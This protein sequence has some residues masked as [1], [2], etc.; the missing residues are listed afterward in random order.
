[1]HNKK[2]QLVDKLFSIVNGKTSQGVINHLKEEV[3]PK[4]AKFTQKALEKLDYT[5]TN[6]DNWTTDKDVNNEIKRLLH[7]YM[8][9]YNDLI[10]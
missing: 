4:G 5:E 3:I 2:H 10:G 1:M 6:P 7:N 9:R 8:I